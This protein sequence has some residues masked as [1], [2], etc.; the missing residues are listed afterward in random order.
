MLIAKQSKVLPMKR[1]L[2]TAGV[3][4]AAM[5]LLMTGAI[6]VPG[7]RVHPARAQDA[8]A[9]DGGSAPTES[10]T[11]KESSTPWNPEH[12][13]A[14]TVFTYGAGVPAF[15]C[16]PGRYCA[17]GLQTGETIRQIS[18]SD[19]TWS[20]TPTTYG[21]GKLAAPVLIISPQ[22]TSLG[23]DLTVT[24]D[25]RV[26]KVKLVSSTEHAMPLAVFNYPSDPAGQAQ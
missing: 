25:R 20:V 11:P 10:G 8:G 21:A 19:P 23:S 16:T 22:G 13:A 24:T 2:P 7:Y 14:S 15:L 5:S 12:V 18:Q 17:L 1:S 3:L 4:L 9:S 26:Y 6:S